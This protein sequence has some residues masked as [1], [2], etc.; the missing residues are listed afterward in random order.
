MALCQHLRCA[1]QFS[2]MSGWAF[3]VIL[4]QA[5][6]EGWPVTKKSLLHWYRWYIIYYTFRKTGQVYQFTPDQWHWWLTGSNL[7]SLQQPSL[8][9][10]D[11][12]RLCWQSKC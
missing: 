1:Q 11:A 4:E 5:G 3:W 12:V 8:L 9:G 10:A 2:H 7:D 6:R